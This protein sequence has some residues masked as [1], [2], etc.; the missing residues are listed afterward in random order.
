[1]TFVYSEYLS[2]H[3]RR[4]FCAQNAEYNA[5]TGSVTVFTGSANSSVGVAACYGLDAPVSKF[6]TGARVFCVYQNVQTGFESHT[7]SY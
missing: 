6:R 3:T 4:I 7:V 5:I 2:G 1:M